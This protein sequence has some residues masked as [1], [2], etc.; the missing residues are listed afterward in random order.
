MARG[1][2]GRRL[3]VSA[4]ALLLWL[5]GE[6]AA[7]AIPD[8]PPSCP[9]AAAGA[10]SKG[11]GSPQS[12]TFVNRLDEDALLLVWVDGYMGVRRP[13][14]GVGTRRAPRAEPSLL[15]RGWGRVVIDDGGRRQQVARQS[16]SPSTID[17]FTRENIRTAAAVA[18]ATPLAESTPFSSSNA[19]TTRACRYSLRSGS[20]CTARR[21][22]RASSRPAASPKSKQVEFRRCNVT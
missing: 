13:R 22:T 15:R 18:I 8:P 12:V 6:G 4:A 1:A 11:G 14:R 2:P 9:S 19:T 20:T 21:S 17:L 3:A 10:A 7:V 5:A 16:R